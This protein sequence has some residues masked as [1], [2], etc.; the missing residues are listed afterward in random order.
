MKRYISRLSTKQKKILKGTATIISIF[1]LVVFSNLFL[2]WCQND[3]SVDLALKFAFSWHTEKFFLACLVLLIILIFLIALAGSVPLGSL[4]YV[5]TIGVLGFANYMKMSYRQE[6]IYPDDLKM[7]T[8]IGLL[9]DMTGTMLFTVILA[10]AGTVLGLFCWYMFRSLKKG[11]RFQLIRLTTLLVAI[12]LLGY[13]SN[14][15]NPDNLLRKAYNKTALWI[16]YS[17]KMNYYNTGFIG[18]FLYNLKVEP[19]DEPEGYSK[20]KIKEITEKY[21]KLA[22][23]KN[24]AVEEESPN[25]VFVM[26]ESFSDPSRLNGV[27]VSGEPLADYYEVADQT[28]SGNMLSQNYGGGTANIEFEALTGFSM[29]LFNAQLTTPYTMLVPKMDQLP[30]IVSALNAQSYQT[31]A[32]H[33]YNTSMYKREDVY[34][35]LGFDQFI[36]ERTMTY[37]DTIENNPYISDESAYKEVMTLLKEEKAPQFIHL[38][39]MQTHMPYNGKYD[40]LGY[41]AEISDGSGTLDLENYLQ[42]ISYSSAALKQFTE[43]LKNL[44]RRTL[45][46]FWGDHLPGIYSDTIQAKNDKQTLHETQFL[47]FDSKGK[48]EKQ[49]T[50]DA[51]TSPFYFAANLMEQTNQTTNGF[52]Q[53]LLSLEQE[54]PAF[55]RELYYQ[56]GQWYKEAQF[57]R[58]QQEIYDEYKLIQ[59]DIVAGKQYSLADGFFE[60][61]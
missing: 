50:Q 44:S 34:Q 43:E 16:P 27:E 13:I 29:A 37:T 5:V 30:S 8:E 55:E 12:G 10:A 2:Q 20:A 32:I 21:Q 7:I 14:F 18:G 48:L 4:T 46:V 28:Y 42:D 47:M 17:Q 9:K 11:R 60:H 24:K 51:I 39:T 31:T 15:N 23:E 45:V 54:L 58:S 40:R 61:E 53:L 49:T 22:D 36:S 33:P 57:N 56:N 35:T 41:S 19:M 3:L 6:P 59:Y 38:V 25:I 26:S 1:F 52:Y